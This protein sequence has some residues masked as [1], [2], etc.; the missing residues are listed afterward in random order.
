VKVEVAKEEMPKEG[1][2]MVEVAKEEMAGKG[3]VGSVMEG[4]T[5]VVEGEMVRKQEPR[6]VLSWR[7]NKVRLELHYQDLQKLHNLQFRR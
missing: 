1:P 4:D 5:A 2:E 3:G 6:F 7:T